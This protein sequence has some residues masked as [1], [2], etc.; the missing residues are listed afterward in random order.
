MSLCALWPF[1]WPLVCPSAHGHP[2]EKKNMGQDWPKAL[3][4]LRESSL[5]PS[6]RFLPSPLLAYLRAGQGTVK[7]ELAKFLGD[8]G[9]ETPSLTPRRNES[10]QCPS[11]STTRTIRGLEVQCAEAGARVN[12][13]QQM[14]GAVGPF[15]GITDSW[16]LSQWFSRAWGL[17]WRPQ[18]G[19]DFLH[20]CFPVRSLHLVELVARTAHGLCSRNIPSLEF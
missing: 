12:N 4:S 5:L 14:S 13:H 16:D 7:S 11:F 17:L 19:L 8:G 1:D 15:W 20:P 3:G 18:P 2:T 9:E 10:G 6:A